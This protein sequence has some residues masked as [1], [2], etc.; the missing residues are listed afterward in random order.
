MLARCLGHISLLENSIAIFVSFKDLANL[1]IGFALLVLLI[2]LV[3]E[4]SGFKGNR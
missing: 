4:I 3:K 2:L 1:A